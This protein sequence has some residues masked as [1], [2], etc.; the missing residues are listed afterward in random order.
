MNSEVFEIALDDILNHPEAVL[1]ELG[2]DD[3]LALVKRLA[4]SSPAAEAALKDCQL[5]KLIESGAKFVTG[6]ICQD[7]DD[8]EESD[9]E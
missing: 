7:P 6:T 5:V 1:C 4:Q 9:H 2:T 8:T 3:A